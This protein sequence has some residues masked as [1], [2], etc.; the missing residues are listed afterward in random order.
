M[1]KNSLLVYTSEK[2]CLPLITFLLETRHDNKMQSK[3]T[4]RQQTLIDIL[5]LGERASNRLGFFDALAPCRENVKHKTSVTKRTAKTTSL[6]VKQQRNCNYSILRDN[7]PRARTQSRW[8]TMNPR[9]RISH[10]FSC[11][12]SFKY[13]S[14]WHKLSEKTNVHIVY[15]V[16]GRLHSWCR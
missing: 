11:L 6:V 15:E 4:Q 13:F 2:I 10:E 5:R 7:W 12:S 8:F 9:T 14:K 16:R 1:N 3:L